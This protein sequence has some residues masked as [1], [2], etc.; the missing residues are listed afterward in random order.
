MEVFVAS[1]SH[2]LPS[3]SS[4]S[5]DLTHVADSSDDSSSEVHARP[6]QEADPSAHPRR[7]MEEQLGLLEKRLQAAQ[8]EFRS[9]WDSP[10][11]AAQVGDVEIS[12]HTS[13]LSD[14][15]C[16]KTVGTG[17]FGRVCLAQHKHNRRHYAI[18]ILQKAKIVKLKQV[19]H[20]LNEKKILSC[21]DFPFIVALKTFFKD[22]SNLYMALEFINGGELFSL[23]R[24]EGKFRRKTSF[25][26]DYFSR[27]LVKQREDTARFYGAQVVLA[28]QYLHSM[29]IAYRDLKPENL[30]ID[31]HGYLKLTDFGFAKVVKG[32]TWTLCGTP[33]YLAPEIILSKGYSRA[34]DWWAVGVLIFEMIAGY[35]PFFADQ[36]LQVYEKIVA[37]KVRFPFFMSTD[38]RA[39]L[40]N[41]LQG[42]TTK[43]YGNM[44]NGV[45]DIQSHVW[46]TGIDWVD[47]LDRKV[48]PPYVPH[49]KD[50]SDASHFDD[51]PEEETTDTT[52]IPKMLYEAEFADF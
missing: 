8:L 24:K 50:D 28:L 30:L 27:D 39:L 43:R 45:A 6:V 23:I 31:R 51:Y 5:M 10:Q 18:K 47:I 29:D 13:Q 42:D 40:S 41:L 32:R 34:V 26:C 11:C 35:P 7:S 22:N 17:S 33:E 19:E 44:R 25:G 16:I 3:K 36:A 46:F 1:E 21:I 4:T 37:G 12:N 38:A 48:K 9:K 49:V 52:T 2:P 14:F 15:T 20:T